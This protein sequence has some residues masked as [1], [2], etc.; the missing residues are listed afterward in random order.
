MK[1]RLTIDAEYPH[2]NPPVESATWFRSWRTYRHTGSARL[3]W[4]GEPRNCA[5]VVATRRTLNNV[6]T[7]A[8]GTAPACASCERNPDYDRRRA[9]RASGRD[10]RRQTGRALADIVSSRSAT[11]GT[12]GTR[13]PPRSHLVRSR[14]GR[15][16]R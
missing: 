2:A 3:L 9:T 12:P 15:R 14:A 13:T 10:G 16:A 6:P 11:A 5:Q 8:R 1:I 7:Q 4:A